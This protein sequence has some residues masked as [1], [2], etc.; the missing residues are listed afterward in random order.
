MHC[1]VKIFDWLLKYLEFKEW[2][3]NYP[4]SNEPGGNH[5]AP[6]VQ[7]LAEIGFFAKHIKYKKGEK[8]AQMEFERQ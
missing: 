6:V 7:S 1:D 2:T 5:R 8:R 4:Q 3:L